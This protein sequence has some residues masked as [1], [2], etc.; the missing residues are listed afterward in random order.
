MDT[1][2]DTEVKAVKYLVF[3]GVTYYPGGGWQDF[4]GE[5]ED[6]NEARALAER[7]H[8]EWCHAVYRD[9]QLGEDGIWITVHVHVTPALPP[10]LTPGAIEQ[11]G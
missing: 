8:C 1:A 3:G 10:W 11:L 6:L 9:D 4:L 2:I 5:V 7:E